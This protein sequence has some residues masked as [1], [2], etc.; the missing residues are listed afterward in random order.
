VK[1]GGREKGERGKLT[2]AKRMDAW[3]EG[4]ILQKLKI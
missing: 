2:F 1:R 4:K 3:E